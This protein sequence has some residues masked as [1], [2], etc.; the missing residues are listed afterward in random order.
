VRPTRPSMSIATSNMKSSVCLQ[1]EREKAMAL[2]APSQW[3]C[4]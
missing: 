1:R 2:E 3:K 4:N